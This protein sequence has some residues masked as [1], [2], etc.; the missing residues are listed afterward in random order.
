ML[1]NEEETKTVMF[2]NTCHSN[3]IRLQQQIFCQGSERTY[4]NVADREDDLGHVPGRQKLPD[5][6]LQ[7]LDKVLGEVCSWRH[8]QE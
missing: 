3:C 4:W 6:A 7:T 1:S 2:L 8:L 5:R